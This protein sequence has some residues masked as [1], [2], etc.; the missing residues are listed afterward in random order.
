MTVNYFKDPIVAGYGVGVRLPLFGYFVRGEYAWGI[1]T[2]EI[3]KP[4]LH[5]AIGYDF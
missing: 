3:M 2:R 4:R 5:F 1:E